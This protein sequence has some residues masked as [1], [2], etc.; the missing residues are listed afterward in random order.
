MVAEG[1]VRRAENQGGGAQ[2]QS[3]PRLLLL[4]LLL[5]SRI[6]IVETFLL[7]PGS[8]MAFQKHCSTSPEELFNNNY[9]PRPIFSDEND[10]Q[11]QIA[12]SADKKL[13]KRT[14]IC[15]LIAQPRSRWNDS[16]EDTTQS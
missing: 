3:H 12:L 5:L 16:R 7:G 2:F 11:V 1:L 8:L 13:H 6:S 4:L 15:C 10:R 14:N 9:Q